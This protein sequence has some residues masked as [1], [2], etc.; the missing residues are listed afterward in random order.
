MVFKNKEIATVDETVGRIYAR[1]AGRVIIYA[2][3]GGKHIHVH[4]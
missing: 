1:N 4:C 2:K 3:E